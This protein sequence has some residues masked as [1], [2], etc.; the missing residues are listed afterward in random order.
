MAEYIILDEFL[1]DETKES[2]DAQGHLYKLVRCKDCKNS[3]EPCGGWD[4]RCKGFG[5]VRDDFFCGDG[6]PK[7]GVRDGV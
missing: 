2:A 7:G 3:I 4:R 1:S 5:V 6:K